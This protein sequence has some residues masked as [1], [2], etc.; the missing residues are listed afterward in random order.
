M[1][2][3]TNFTREDEQDDSSS[4]NFAIFLTTFVTSAIKQK[5]RHKWV[6]DSEA[7]N[8][9]WNSKESLRYFAINWNGYNMGTEKKSRYHAHGNVKVSTYVNR[10]ICTILHR[11]VILASEMMSNLISQCRVG[12]ANLKIFIEIDIS[13]H[14]HGVTRLVH[15]GVGK[16]SLICVEGPERLRETVCTVQSAHVAKHIDMEIWH[17]RLCHTG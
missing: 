17:H 12:K 8:H 11:Y 13:N 6:Y 7:R 4:K 2:K 1:N 3:K 15:E 16:T 5:T 9:A 10:K 14:R